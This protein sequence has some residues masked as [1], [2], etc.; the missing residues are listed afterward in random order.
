MFRYR[1]GDLAKSVRATSGYVIISLSSN[2]T[3]EL[4]AYR[5]V[6]PVLEHLSQVAIQ[7]QQVALVLPRTKSSRKQCTSKGST[8]SE[9]PFALRQLL[10]Q[11]EFSSMQ[12]LL[13]VNVYRIQSHLA[14]ASSSYCSTMTTGNLQD[15]R[16]PST[17]TQE[18][19]HDPTK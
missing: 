12:Q 3:I 7:P 11:V 1:Y 9:V 8:A 18:L 6:G 4:S 17:Y 15:R 2:I 14:N 13:L 16:D 5:S 10:H 19:D